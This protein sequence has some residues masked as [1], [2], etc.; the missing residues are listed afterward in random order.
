MPASAAAAIVASLSTATVIE[1]L[2]GERGE[3]LEP[4]G[5]DDLVGDEEVVAEPGGG[6]ARPPRVASR[7]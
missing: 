5:V 2:V 1:R 6:H 3:R 4:P 7:T